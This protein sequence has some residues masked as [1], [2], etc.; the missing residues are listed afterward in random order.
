MAAAC[1][2]AEGR[3]EEKRR[4]AEAEVRADL[5]LLCCGS[6]GFG[7]GTGTPCTDT[8]SANGGPAPQ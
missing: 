6:V 3:R 4:E 5:V 8:V 7:P 1:M 2:S